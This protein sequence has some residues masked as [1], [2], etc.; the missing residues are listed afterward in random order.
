M[1][2]AIENTPGLL[3]ELLGKKHL[4]FFRIISS[5]DNEAWSAPDHSVRRASMEKRRARGWR[6][7][8]GRGR[9]RENLKTS[10]KALIK[11]CLKLVFLDFS[12][13]WVKNT[14][15]ELTVLFFF[16]FSEASWS[17][18]VTCTHTHNLIY[19]RYLIFV[20]PFAFRTFQTSGQ[21]AQNQRTKR[22]PLF[23]FHDT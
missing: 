5:K 9:K 10:F 21:H 15:Q 3:W 17:Y 12:F 19:N 2:W 8:N 6:E 23:L 22:S 11:P 1:P 20:R 18:I 16:F 14:N 13:T 7:E 4:F